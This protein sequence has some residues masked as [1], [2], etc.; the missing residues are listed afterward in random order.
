MENHRAIK[1]LHQAGTDLN[2]PLDKD[3]QHVAL[4][5]ELGLKFEGTYWALLAF[6]V[7]PGDREGVNLLL[8]LGASANWPGKGRPECEAPIFAALRGAKKRGAKPWNLLPLLIEAGADVNI[9]FRSFRPLARLVH[10]MS[11][12]G[13]YKNGYAAH[14]TAVKRLIAAGAN[15]NV[16]IP[17]SP[18]F[19]DK[20]ERIVDLARSKGLKYIVKLLE[21]AG[22]E[23]S[24]WYRV[25]SRNSINFVSR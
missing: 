8:R 24:K 14:C 21:E 18:N 12:S 3:D 10:E 15:V 19:A 16:T 25:S 5:R 7:S 4:I 11:P 2:K 1:L 23:R 9:E 13:S 20:P 6:S 22:A 17:G